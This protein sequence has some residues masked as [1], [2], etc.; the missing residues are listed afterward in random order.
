MKWIFLSAML[1][2]IACNDSATVTK[3]NDVDNT[4]NRDTTNVSDSVSNADS[5]R[6][7]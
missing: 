3:P 5:L 1:L 2:L 7:R 4:R 6:G